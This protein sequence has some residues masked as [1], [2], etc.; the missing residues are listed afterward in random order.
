MVTKLD[1]IITHLQQ[2]PPK[3]LLYPF[4][5]GLEISHEKQKSFSLNYPSVYGDQICQIGEFP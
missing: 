2:F 5:R 1:R 4:I 3:K